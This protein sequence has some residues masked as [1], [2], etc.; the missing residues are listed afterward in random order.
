MLERPLIDFLIKHQDN[1]A[2]LKGFDISF[3]I[4]KIIQYPVTLTCDMIKIMC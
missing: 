3:D 4:G 2:K 1:K